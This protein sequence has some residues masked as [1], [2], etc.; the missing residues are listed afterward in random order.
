MK[1]KLALAFA[2]LATFTMSCGKEN[3]VKSSNVKETAAEYLAKFGE[4][5]VIEI[6]YDSNEEVRNAAKVIFCGNFIYE[7]HTLSVDTFDGKTVNAH[8]VKS[9]QAFSQSGWPEDEFAGPV[10]VTFSAAFHGPLYNLINA[11]AY[12]AEHGHKEHSLQ[13]CITAISVKKTGDKFEAIPLAAYPKA[14]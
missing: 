6:A 7:D 12:H 4:A 10:E 1:S 3:H 14:R 13:K 9:F 5:T 8:P 11:G 2:T